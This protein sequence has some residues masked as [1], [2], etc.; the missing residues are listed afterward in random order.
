MRDPLAPLFTGKV[1]EVAAWRQAGNLRMKSPQCSNRDY[2]HNVEC[3]YGRSFIR[4]NSLGA[5]GSVILHD[6]YPPTRR[7]HKNISLS[8]HNPDGNKNTY[9]IQSGGK[10]KTLMPG[11]EIYR[12]LKI[13]VKISR[14]RW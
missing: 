11:N 8:K 14:T 4:S 7:M 12:L 10:K 1:I 13:H 9:C 2:F 3:V 5:G 6:V